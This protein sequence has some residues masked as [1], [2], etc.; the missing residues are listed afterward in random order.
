MVRT[1]KAEEASRK[2]NAEKADPNSTAE[3]P[4]LTEH[5]NDEVPIETAEEVTTTDMKISDEVCPDEE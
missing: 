3:K 5:Q 2:E 4:V 1:L